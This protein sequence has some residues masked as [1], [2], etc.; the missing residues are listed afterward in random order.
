MNAS[1]NYLWL[2]FGGNRNAVMNLNHGTP[3]FDPAL[4]HYV[5]RNAN[6]DTRYICL[7]VEREYAES[8]LSIIAY[9]TATSL[10]DPAYFVGRLSWALHARHADAVAKAIQTY[11][12]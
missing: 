12:A 5:G 9:L 7:P 8:E 1:Q 6:C 4:G 3:E 11:N 2:P 10:P